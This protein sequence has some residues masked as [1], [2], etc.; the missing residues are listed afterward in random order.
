MNH[1]KK[2]SFFIV[3]LMLY[4]CDDKIPSLEKLNQAPKIEYFSRSTTNWTIASDTIVDLAKVYNKNNNINYTVAIRSIDANKNFESIIVTEAE[5]GGK[6]YLDDKEFTESTIVPLDSFSLAYRYYKAETREF[7]VESKDDFGM[8]KNIVF[9]ITFLENKIPIAVLEIRKINT[10]AQNEYILDASKSEDQDKILGGFIT[11]YEYT[12]NDVVI[13]NPS[14]QIYHVF[15]PG[16]HTV[17]LRVK[18]NDELWSK[19][20]IRNLIIQ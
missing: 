4:Q 11:K 7:K 18:D 12:V 8:L 15:M 3:L 9:Q 10:N 14:N 19:Q 5:S 16:T 13:E 6:F 17:G 1:I 20:I 2:I